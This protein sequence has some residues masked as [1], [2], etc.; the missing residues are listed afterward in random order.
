M[1]REEIIKEFRVRELLEA[2]RRVIGKYGFQ[3]ATIDRVADEAQVAKGTVYLYFDNKD[4]L[5]HVA[6]L[7]GIRTMLHEL[8]GNGNA[9]QSPLEHLKSI[10]R[11]QFR[12]LDSNQDFVKALLLESS[13]VSFKPGDRRAEEIRAIFLTYLDFLSGIFREAIAAG[14]VRPIAPDLCAFMLHELV[15]GSLLRRMLG[16]ATTPLKEDAESVLELFLRGIEVRCAG[17]Q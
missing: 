7:N 4:D 14:E 17:S 5:L 11:Q 2:T 15:T 8:K 1:G 16:L 13:L 6:I 12:L 9:G 10:V 3:G